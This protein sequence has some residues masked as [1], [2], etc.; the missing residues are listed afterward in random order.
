MQCTPCGGRQSRHGT[1]WPCAYA[2]QMACLASEGTKAISAHFESDRDG[3]RTVRT[4]Y[5]P[6]V[7][8][9]GPSEA[10]RELEQSFEW[11][12]GWLEVGG[13]VARRVAGGSSLRR[14]WMRGVAGDSRLD[15]D[16]GWGGTGDTL[17]AL[18]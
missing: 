17:S 14:S 7:T 8:T 16:G 1:G 18:R 12:K 5:N 2:G 13:M 4:A 9:P 10:Q 11:L 15:V 3:L 6:C